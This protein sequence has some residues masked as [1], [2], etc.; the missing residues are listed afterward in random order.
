VLQAGQFS[1][2]PSA[3]EGMGGAVIAV[4]DT[5]LDPFV[6]PAKTGR[7]R[8]GRVFLTPFIHSVSGERGGGRSIPLGGGGSWG[9]WSAMGLF[10]F[11]QL[12]RAGPAWNLPT[13][14]RSAFNQYLAGSLSR[15]LSSSMSIG[16][17][18]QVATLDAIDGVDL[19]YMGSDRIE[20]EGNLADFRA[21]LTRTFAGDRE[22]EVL[23]VHSRN[24]MTHDVRFTTWQWD[25]VN[26]TTIQ[27]SRREVNED[28]TYIWGVHSEYS[29]PVGSAG[30]RLGWLGTA[31]R[32]SHPKIPN[33]VIQNIPRDPGTTYS[34]NAGVGLGRS[35]RGTSFA[36]DLV[37]EPIFA[38]TWADAANDTAV[39]Q[40]PI[41]RKG[42]RTVENTF[43]FH[44]V[45]LRVGA[46]H[47]MN[48]GKGKTIIG[49]QAGLA[50]HSINY[51]L[52]QTLNLLDSARTQREDWIEWTPTLGL[53]VRSRDL[54][55]MYN[56][57]VT[58]GPGSCSSGQVTAIPTAPGLE[59]PGGGGIIAAP[60]SELFM[61]SGSLKVHKLTVSL[62]IR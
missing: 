23:L 32:L 15:R 26:R 25:A 51:K 58:C 28:R 33:Y 11:Q 37:L 39:A 7:L 22:L 31:N 55:V 24:D 19:L 30:W 2:Y 42:D 16:F 54:D 3:R 36:A 46:G 44:N 18:A 5:L 21:G 56:F 43:R 52:D 59:T 45:K 10:T 41:I 4:D 60:S 17:S 61:Q 14:E 35:V 13:A 1:M 29:R 40:G 38:E 50:V 48:V 62:P 34:F 20:Q 9:P 27:N 12:D 57:S 8:E 6:N 53:R 47:D 49:Y